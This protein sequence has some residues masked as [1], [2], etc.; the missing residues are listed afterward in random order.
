MIRTIQALKGI[1]CHLRIIGK[2]NNNIIDLLKQN[3][4]EYSNDWN[5]T[6]EQIVQEYQQADIINFPSLYEG[7][8]MPII[9]GQASGRIVITSNISPMKD[10]AGDG[11]ILIDPFDDKSIK[12]AY[13]AVI[14]DQNLRE[15]IIQKGFSNAKKYTIKNQYYNIYK[16]IQ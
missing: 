11:A 15:N 8:G 12:K 14:K 1:S 10:V 3:K 13:L 7:F 6:H 4:I 2:I 5:L 9:E 16:T